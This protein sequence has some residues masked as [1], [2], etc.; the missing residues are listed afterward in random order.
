MF[1][2]REKTIAQELL[3][4]VLSKDILRYMD[5]LDI[6]PQ[7]IVETTA[8]KALGEIQEILKTYNPQDTDEA[9][10][11][12]MIEKILHVFDTYDLNTGDCHDFG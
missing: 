1:E 10:D 5:G 7:K 12:M 3:A 11:F 8:I 4:H 9:A 6:Q 2:D